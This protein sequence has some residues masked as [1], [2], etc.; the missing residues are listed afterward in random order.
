MNFL[1]INELVSGKINLVQDSKA[2][3]LESR[4][5]GR[6]K[7]NYHENTPVKQL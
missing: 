7:K 6:L 5:A 4:E 3:R 2:G 1:P